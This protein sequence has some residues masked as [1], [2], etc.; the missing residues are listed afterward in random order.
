MAGG[1]GQDAGRGGLAELGAGVDLLAVLEVVFV[2]RR[3]RQRRLCQRDV[4]GRAQGPLLTLGLSEVLGGLEG[5][6]REQLLLP[7]GVFPPG[8]QREARGAALLGA[9]L[10]VLWS[11][12]GVADQT[13]WLGGG[14]LRLPSFG[15]QQLG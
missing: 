10:V 4:L 2:R 11:A 3:S 7:A 1:L 15:L 5:R 12:V 8:G 13:P 9:A 14:T 6:G